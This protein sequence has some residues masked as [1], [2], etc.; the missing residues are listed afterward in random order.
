MK[1]KVDYFVK[2]KDTGKVI[3]VQHITLSESDILDKAKEMVGENSISFRENADF[4]ID[5]VVND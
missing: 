5:Q 3:M 1:I 2:N 4:V